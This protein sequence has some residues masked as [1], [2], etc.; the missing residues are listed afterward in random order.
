M[1]GGANLFFA[2]QQNK[3]GE[4]TQGAQGEGAAEGAA[5]GSGGGGGGGEEPDTGEDLHHWE[6]ELGHGPLYVLLLK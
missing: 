4:A 6:E 2:L 5:E 1:Q 3:E